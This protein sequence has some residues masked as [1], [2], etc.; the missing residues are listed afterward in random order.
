MKESKFLGALLPSSPDFV[1]II[2][3]V[4]E[5]YNIH[6]PKMDLD[7]APINEMYLIA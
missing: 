2:E 3:A 4:R 1:P 6:I 7:D 5:K